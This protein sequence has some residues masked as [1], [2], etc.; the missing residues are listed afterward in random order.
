MRVCDVLTA[1]S[2]LERSYVV[3]SSNCCMYICLLRRGHVLRSGDC[4]MY[5]SVAARLCFAS[6]V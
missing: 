3:L 5:V 1:L 6:G 2:V 4:C